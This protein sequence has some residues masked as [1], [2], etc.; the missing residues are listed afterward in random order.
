[1]EAAVEQLGDAQPAGPLA[2]EVAKAVREI[3][4][5]RPSGF[6][7]VAGFWV[8]DEWEKAA[9]TPA[10]HAIDARPS[11]RSPARDRRTRIV[12]AAKNRLPV[13]T[14]RWSRN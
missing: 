6:I 3:A 14:R 13:H 2:D 12:P 4:T 8:A 5:Q 9:A 11:S 10:T 1:M 7:I